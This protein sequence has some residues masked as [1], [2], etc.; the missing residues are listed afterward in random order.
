MKNEGRWAGISKTTDKTTNQPN[1][2]T[3]STQQPI[4]P[5]RPNQPQASKQARQP[6]TTHT[7][8]VHAQ[9]RAVRVRRV[10]ARVVLAPRVRHGDHR[11]QLLGVLQLDAELVHPRTVRVPDPRGAADAQRRNVLNVE[12]G[13]D[14]RPLRRILR[15]PGVHADLEAR[16]ADVGAKGGEV[17]IEL[18]EI[19]REFG[20]AL[21]FDTA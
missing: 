6:G 11:R 9:T 1:R 18:V 13:F 19:A 17:R 15:L 5:N 12:R 20:D 14:R 3:Q 7:G 21:N 16:L 2:S 8:R 10:A 4:Q